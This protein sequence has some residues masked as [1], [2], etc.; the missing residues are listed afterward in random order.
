MLLTAGQCMI[1]PF[2]QLNQWL[3]QERSLGAPNPQQAVLAT[4]TKAAV[5]QA[6]V[7]AIREIDE[8]GFL[9]FTQKGTRKVQALNE[10]PVA[11]LT[12]WFE[13]QQRQVVV[14]GSVMALSEVENERYWQTYPRVAQQRFH[15]Y[16]PTSSQ[17]IASKAILERKRERLSIVFKDNPIPMSEHYCG[18]LL[19]PES[20]VFYAYRLDELS[21]V[22]QYRRL[23]DAW[24]QQLLSP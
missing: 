5:P 13:L 24:Q 15:S 6:R 22:V 20:M 9:F 2:T 19:K 7:V 4:A 21:D 14:E 1:E 11:A 3:E 8:K 17:V 18:F 23:D 12:F 10:N 16:A